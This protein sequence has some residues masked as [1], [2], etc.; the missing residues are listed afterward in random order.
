MNKKRLFEMSENELE[1]RLLD[2]K[3][4]YGINANLLFNLIKNP[5]YANTINQRL[6]KHAKRKLQRRLAGSDTVFRLIE[7]TIRQHKE[8][9]NNCPDNYQI[10]IN[11]RLDQA[12]KIAYN[13]G[14]WTPEVLEIVG[15]AQKKYFHERAP[16][17]AEIESRVK[18]TPSGEYR[19]NWSR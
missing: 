19:K 9:L 13:S 16:S 14:Q 1:G 18:F 12:Q 11:S 8:S 15:E 10:F 5:Q 2:I 7:E 3:N 6:S 17:H 4:R